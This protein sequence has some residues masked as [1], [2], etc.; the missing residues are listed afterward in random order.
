MSGKK[1]GLGRGLDALLGSAPAVASEDSSLTQAGSSLLATGLRE[2]PVDQIERGQYQPRQRFDEEALQELAASIKEHGLMQ[3]VVVVEV[4]PNRF[5]LIAGER[6]WRACQR[7]GLETIPALIRS[8]EADQ[9]LAMALIENI[10]RENLNPMEEAIAL[11]RLIEEFQLTH[12]AVADSVGKSRT[13]V[14][15]AIRLTRLGQEAANLVAEGALDM[16]HGRALL[17][18]PLE[19]QG[20]AARQIIAKGMSVRQAEGLV[21]K[22]LSPSQA[23]KTPTNVGDP[24]VV[25]LER[26]LSSFLGQQVAIK[27]QSKSK[28]QLNIRYDSLDEL[29]GILNRLG[30]QTD[31]D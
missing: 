27:Q 1:R 28:G 31:H 8:V 21:R 15:N 12:Q 13:A 10:Q 30:F 23:V 4:A 29:E 18:L 6:R 24:D 22:M 2:I 11:S 25:R 3:P 14:T 19:Q 7:V 26:Q 16:G 17:A 9:Q 5:Q 20:P